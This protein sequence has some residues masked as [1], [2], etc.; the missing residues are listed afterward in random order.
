MGREK[1]ELKKRRKFLFFVQPDPGVQENDNFLVFFLSLSFL[2]GSA[3]LTRTLFLSL[4]F[5]LF[6]LLFAIDQHQ[7]R[8]E[9][10][11][12][13]VKY[14]KVTQCLFEYFMHKRPITKCLRKRFLRRS[15]RCTD[16][17][18]DSWDVLAFW[19]QIET[20]GIFKGPT[21]LESESQHTT[22]K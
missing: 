22:K 16:T 12:N 4:S 21:V 7:G 17:W 15:I 19:S 6:L 9:R 5:S 1:R 14:S 3:A 11:K 10:K 8:R 2:G 20:V 13:F 18:R